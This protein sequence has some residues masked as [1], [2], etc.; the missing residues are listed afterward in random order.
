MQDPLKKPTSPWMPF[1]TLISVLSKF[2][3]PQSV[4]S[5]AKHHRDHRVCN[6][7]A[8]VLIYKMLFHFV[9]FWFSNNYSFKFVLSRRIRFRDT[10]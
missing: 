3:P 10:S 4:N 6:F 5:I 1:S 8:T 7:Q 2:L 9:I